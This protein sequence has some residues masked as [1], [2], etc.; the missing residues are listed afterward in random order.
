MMPITYGTITPAYYNKNW[1][2]LLKNHEGNYVTSLQ[3]KRN[4]I[5]VFFQEEKIIIQVE[6]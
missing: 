2:Y 5:L 3:L 1:C 6:F 4:L